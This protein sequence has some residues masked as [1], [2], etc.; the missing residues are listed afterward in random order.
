MFSIN[1]SCGCKG[2]Q[3]CSLC[4][5]SNDH[6]KL[7]INKDEHRERSKTLFKHIDKD[8][9]HCKH[10][11]E[12]D[13]FDQHISLWD[14][15]D[16]ERCKCEQHK[17][18]KCKCHHCEKKSCKCEHCDEHKCKCEYEMHECKWDDCVVNHCE[19]DFCE[20][21]LCEYDFMDEDSC[22]YVHKPCPDEVKGYDLCRKKEELKCFKHCG[23]ISQPC[24][25]IFYNHFTS[26]A[27]MDF[28]G[29]IVVKNTGNPN[30]GCAMK[31]CV[32]DRA[33][34]S[35]VAIVNPGA[36]VPIFV[37]GLITL[38]IACFRNESEN[39]ATTLCCG[40]VIFDL[41]YCTT[42]YVSHHH[43]EL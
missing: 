34:T 12:E 36:S 3:S 9:E 20:I 23:P 18:R 27:N 14:D 41:E 6:P 28:S 25:S 43:D 1:R 22:E 11:Q 24:D 30:S 35:I 38:E 16:K 7:Y 26:R 40:E 15:C 37:E 33:G 5:R 19:C 10:H 2:T 21:K 29:L 13:D 42:R 39:P 17:K 31:V 4:Q 8:K 32:T